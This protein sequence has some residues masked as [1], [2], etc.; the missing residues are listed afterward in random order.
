MMNKQHG[1]RLDLSS[2]ALRNGDP[3]TLVRQARELAEPHGFTIGIQMHNISTALE[4]E[5]MAQLGV[6]L[7]FHAPVISEYMMNFAAEDPATAWQA[8]EEQVL[9]MRRYRVN[10]AVF[11]AFRMTDQ[12]VPAFGHGLS[13]DDCMKPARRDE[14]MRRSGSRFVCDF[15]GLEEFRLR[16]DRLKANLAKLRKRYPQIVWCVEND[17]PAYGAGDL[18]GGDLAYLENPVCIDTGHMWATAKMLNLDFHREIQTALD[19]GNVQMIHLH[20]SRY[21]FSM[22][23]ELWGDGHLPLDYPNDMDL[24]AVVKA[25]KAA[26]VPHFVLE[27]PPMTIHDVETFLR[28]YGE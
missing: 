27:I 9:L 4:L 13:Y 22:D 2:V 17:F 7:S 6:P 20:A 5:S 16:R 1:L 14:L 10:R 26:G 8:A 21:K 18:R 15:T 12:A 23:A 24:P 25:C 3:E 11:H 28:F 19:S